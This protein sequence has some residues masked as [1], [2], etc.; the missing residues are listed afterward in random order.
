MEPQVVNLLGSWELCWVPV[1]HGI[2]LH[3]RQWNRY[4]APG[5]GDLLVFGVL[6]GAGLSL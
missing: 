4:G 5:E 6:C 3:L 2:G 1:Q